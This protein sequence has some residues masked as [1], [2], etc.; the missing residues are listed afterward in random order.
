MPK[1]SIGRAAGRKALGAGSNL[2]QQRM[3][4]PIPQYL[5][6]SHSISRAAS[7]TPSAISGVASPAL[8]FATA[9]EGPS[10]PVTM[11]EVRPAFVSRLAD[12]FHTPPSR[13]ASPALPQPPGALM[14]HDGEETGDVGAVQT[15]QSIL[16][17][18]QL[19]QTAL[20]LALMLPATEW[21]FQFIVVFIGWFGF[22]MRPMNSSATR[23]TRARRI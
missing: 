3:A 9:I 2:T 10:A 19:T 14:F 6:A 23:N 11:R 22:W 13:P 20:E 21:I 15:R 18:A 5:D 7:P 16:P 17:P 4:L 12:S 8:S 1:W